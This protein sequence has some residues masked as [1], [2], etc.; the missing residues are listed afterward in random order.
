[1]TAL[2][3]NT[4][5][6]SINEAACFETVA[7]GAAVSALH[8]GPIHEVGLRNSFFVTAAPFDK[9]C[10]VPYQNTNNDGS[11]LKSQLK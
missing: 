9:I 10:K 1:M 8:H 5:V 2:I 7:I 6:Q 11:Q 3:S 4:C